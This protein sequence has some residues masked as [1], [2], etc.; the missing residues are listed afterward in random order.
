MHETSLTWRL[1]GLLLRTRTGMFFNI[2]RIFLLFVFFRLKVVISH[3]I[4]SAL[5]SWQ[6]RKKCLFIDK[7]GPLQGNL[8]AKDRH[9]MQRGKNPRKTRQTGCYFSV[10]NRTKIEYAC[11][12][13]KR[14]FLAR[15]PSGQ[16]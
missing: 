7:N 8:S 12:G 2:S 4:Y 13:V 14:I 5:T 10:F 6:D 9:V 11:F 3:Y 16:R 1:F 15:E